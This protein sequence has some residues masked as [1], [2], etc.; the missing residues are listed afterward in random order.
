MLCQPFIV[1]LQLLL[2]GIARIDAVH[3]PRHIQEEFYLI[4]SRLDIAHIENPELLNAFVP[5]F[6]HL[7]VE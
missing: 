4:L 5:G 6:R 3:I 1:R 7:L 2:W